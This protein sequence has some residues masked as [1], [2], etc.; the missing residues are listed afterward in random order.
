MDVDVLEAANYE[1]KMTVTFTSSGP[2]TTISYE[3]TPS[4]KIV[5][6]SEVNPSK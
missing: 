3:G 5:Q 4:A 6:Q 1:C 2:Y